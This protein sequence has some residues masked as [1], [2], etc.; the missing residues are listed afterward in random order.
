MHRSEGKL[1]EIR[2]KD[3]GTFSGN[4]GPFSGLPL[5]CVMF[6]VTFSSL[7]DVSLAEDRSGG[8]EGRERNLVRI[9]MHL[10]RRK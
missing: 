4:R 3:L 2:M 6:Q 9:N 7:G 8:P 1:R 5:R 10:S